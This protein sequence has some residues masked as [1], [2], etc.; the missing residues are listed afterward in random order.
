[1]EESLDGKVT[2]S[3]GT[4]SNG[5]SVVVKETM[6]ENII[7]TNGNYALATFLS[8]LIMEKRKHF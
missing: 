8:K 7:E 3:S 1:M 6:N 2:D 5:V 4:C